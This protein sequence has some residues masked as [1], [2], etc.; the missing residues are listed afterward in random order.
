MKL[1]KEKK[2]KEKMMKQMAYLVQKVQ[3]N[4][5]YKEEFQR[6]TEEKI[7]LLKKFLSSN[8]EL[9]LAISKQ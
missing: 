3:V 5:S 2:V 8:N 4:A 9:E 6:L 1:E 7:Q